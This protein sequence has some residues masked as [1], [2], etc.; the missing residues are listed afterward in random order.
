MRAGLL[1]L[2]LSLPAWADIAPA[3]TADC[4]GKSAG[5]ACTTPDGNAGTCVEMKF[6]RPDYSQG[7]P[8]RGYTTYTA[9][10]CKQTAPAASKP[11]R[12]PPIAP[13][14]APA[15][16]TATSPIRS[17]RASETRF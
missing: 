3:E 5:A 16:P 9:L 14:M 1:L 2:V 11:P 7:V 17:A 8:P 12:G 10:G 4:R 13:P 15:A 6:S